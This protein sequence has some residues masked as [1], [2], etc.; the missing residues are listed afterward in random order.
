MRIVR[1]E[2]S[3]TQEDIHF[4]FGQDWHIDSTN[5]PIEFWRPLN[6]DDDDLTFTRAQDTLREEKKD[7]GTE[8]ET[9]KET[10]IDEWPRPDR[11]NAT[12]KKWERGKWMIDWQEEKSDLSDEQ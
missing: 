6:K 1:I 11:K 8:R 3:R 5:K 10:V 9:Q 7:F 4:H 12:L 2:Q